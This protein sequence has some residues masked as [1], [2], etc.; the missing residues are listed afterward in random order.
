MVIWLTPDNKS[1]FSSIW[2]EN[3]MK[4][5]IRALS[6]I[7]ED[8]QAIAYVLAY[9]QIQ[10]KIPPV[11]ED[12]CPSSDEIE[13]HLFRYKTTPEDEKACMAVLSYMLFYLDSKGLVLDL[14]QLIQSGILGS[15]VASAEQVKV[16]DGVL[17][18]P[19]FAL[20]ID[21]RAYAGN[22]E[23]KK[24]RCNMNLSA[25]HAEAFKNALNL[26]TVEFNDK[27]SYIGNEAFSGTALTSLTLPDTV[28]VIEDNAF[29][30][31]RR[32]REL[33][34]QEGL[35][36]IGEGAFRQCVSLTEVRV[37]TTCSSL[38]EGAF[39]LCNLVRKYNL[40]NIV[41]IGNYCFYDNRSLVEITLPKT[42]NKLGKNVFEGCEELKYIH[43][44]ASIPNMDKDAFVGIPKDCKIIVHADE[45]GD[46]PVTIGLYLN[47]LPY[48][49][50]K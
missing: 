8:M 22:T 21:T 6:S 15:V 49:V 30:G 24:L 13:T 25:I 1:A 32:L 12:A 7:P 5:S 29:T 48:E 11:D 37:P 42:L 46:S 41:S 2:S 43:L 4:K 28:R 33:T 34:L 27:L 38:G 36:A 26:S 40:P 20:Y 39:S 3:T 16:V 23:V 14:N 44:P 18:L 50:V 47:K 19:T 35:L 31:C 10:G 9:Y 17:S 45:N